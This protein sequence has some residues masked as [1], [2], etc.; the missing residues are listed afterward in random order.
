M[1]TKTVFSEPEHNL[2]NITSS[3]NPLIVVAGHYSLADYLQEVSNNGDAEAASFN[4]GVKLVNHAINEGRSS[5]LVLL[6]NDIGLNK[7]EREKVK[8][9]YKLPSNYFDIM[10]RE[11]L[12]VKFLTII[13]ESFVRNK[14]STL[15]RK[16]YKRKPYLFERT[17]SADSELCRCVA[18]SSCANSGTEIASS[19][20]SYVIKGLNGEKLVVKDGP[21]PK[22]NLILA[23]FFRDIC[24]KF[25]PQII[26]NIFN[27]VYQNRIRLG[28]Y[29][30]KEILDVTISM[31]NVFSEG[32]EILLDESD[33]FDSSPGITDKGSSINYEIAL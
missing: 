28:Q 14:A 32:S 30:G 16:L 2:L 31:I 9:G 8:N 4:A 21:N 23:T 26:V 15:L 25:K 20:I 22:C 27:N 7:K 3:Q 19:N 17:D 24:D 12:D 1:S 11:G 33:R 6:I 5:Q 18:K 13:F 10:H 29:V